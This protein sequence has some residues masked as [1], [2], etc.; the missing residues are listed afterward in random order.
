M[1]KLFFLASIASLFSSCSVMMAS[2]MQGVELDSIPNIRSRAELI[3]LAEPIES[4]RN[5]DGERVEIY[6]ILEQKGSIARAVM[7]GLLDI[8]TGF[9]WEFAGTPIES[10]LTQDKFISVK[11]TFDA[12]D[13]IKKVELL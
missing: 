4:R 6:K 3:A 11:V 1:R 2:K 12:E 8:S 13:Q 9:L 7:H 5:D 10:A